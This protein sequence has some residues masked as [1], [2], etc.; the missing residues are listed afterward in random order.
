VLRE[1]LGIVVTSVALAPALVAARLSDAATRGALG[2]PGA[3][4]ALGIAEQPREVIA[5]TGGHS[6]AVYELRFARA[7]LVL[8]HA[9]E[10]G[11]ILARGAR[12]CG[13]Q[14]YPV[15]LSPAARTAREAAALDHLARAGVRA[16]RVIAVNAAAGMLLLEHVPGV[17]L[18]RASSPAGILAYRA[19]LDAAHAAGLVLNDAH[20]GNAL[21]D[22]GRIALIDLEFAERSS[23]PSRR[24]FDLAY[25]AAY[26][27]A[28]ERRVFLRDE[29]DLR[30]AA[31]TRKLAA[32][33]P[34][35]AYEAARQRAAS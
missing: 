17:P 23:D 20:P 8:K 4:A 32:Y 29:H 22:G 7:T 15:D 16:P 1:A 12:R 24:A 30:V 31:A 6:S 26:F 25:A 11:S 34:L 33:A 10:A 27:N 13:P 3:L 21:V 9:L 19:A 35:F 5:L 2:I 18:P 28:A 14:P